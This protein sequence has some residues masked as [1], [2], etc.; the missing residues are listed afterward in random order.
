MTGILALAKA[1][2]PESSWSEILLCLKQ[3][4]VPH[5]PFKN[6]HWGQTKPFQSLLMF[7]YLKHPKQTSKLRVTSVHKL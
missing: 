2:F 3:S 4:T 7:T 6:F 5:F 1:Q